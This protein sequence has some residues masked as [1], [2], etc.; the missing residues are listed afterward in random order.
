MTSRTDVIDAAARVITRRCDHRV[1]WVAIAYEAGNAEAVRVAEWFEDLTA[2]IDECYSRSAQGLSDSLLRAETAPGT[3]LDKLAAFLVAALEIRRARGVFLSFR[4]G[5][6]LPQPL[7]RRLHEHDTTVRMRLKRL[8]NKGRRD[9]SLALRN[10]DSAV[11]LL[12]A[13]LQ[14]P[15]VVV[16]GP[17]QRMWDSELVEL[18]LAAL[19]EP[20]PPEAEPVKNVAV[21]HGSCLCGHIRYDIDGPFEVMS[22]CHCSMCRRHHGAA[23]ATFV[24]VPLSG[25]H[26]VAG[27]N[28]ISTYQSSSY[29]KRTFCGRCGSV[30]PVVEPETGVVFCPAGNLDA[31]FGIR[32]PSH[33]LAS[34]KAWHAL[35]G[36]HPQHV[37]V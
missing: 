31:E 17:E 3:A 13:S 10:L 24:S 33:R 18:L 34:S 29:G 15:T 30:T 12:L 35:A 26:W 8:L 5:G 36:E 22:H 1:P 23:F 19:T 28:D 32:S 37:D 9:G 7:L 2:L 6:D 21:I 27:E 16:D 20:H 25:F 14:V 11:E 4:R